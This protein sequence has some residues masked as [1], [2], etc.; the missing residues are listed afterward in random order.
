[1]SGTDVRYPPNAD[2]PQEVEAGVAAVAREINGRPAIYLS[3]PITTGKRYYDFIA[4]A[5]RQLTGT[6]RRAALQRHVVLPNIKQ[7]QIVATSVEQRVQ[8][9]VINPAGYEFRGWSQSDYT[10]MWSRVICEI[11]ESVVCVDGWEYSNGCAYEFLTLVKANKECR[12]Q[13]ADAIAPAQG[14]NGIDQAAS[15]I[16]K[17]GLDCRFLAAVCVDLRRLI[18]RNDHQ[19]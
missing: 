3:T 10:V 7:A 14:L 12:D 15:E 11:A 5:G 13:N 16:A 4:G 19:Q 9:Y 2:H 17:A 6:A 8:K 18:E 1:M